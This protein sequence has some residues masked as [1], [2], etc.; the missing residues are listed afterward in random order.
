MA[1]EICSVC[2]RAFRVYQIDDKSRSAR[3]TDVVCPYGHHIHRSEVSTRT[4][5]TL[6]E[7]SFPRIEPPH[8]PN[9]N[10]GKSHMS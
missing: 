2:G 1:V 6:P 3:N 4:Y 9:P 8:Q 10:D 5:V 7:G